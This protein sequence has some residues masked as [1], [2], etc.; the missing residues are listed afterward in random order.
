MRVDRTSG[1]IRGV[2][3]LGAKS[4][5]NRIYLP[6]AIKGGLHLYEGISVRIGHRKSPNELRDPAEMFGW[7]RKCRIGEDG[8]IFADLHFLKSHPMAE[9]V[10]EA[11]ERNPQL[12]CLSHDAT[13][14]GENDSEGRFRVRK[15]TGLKSVDVVVDGGVNVSLFEERE[16]SIAANDMKDS[17]RAACHEHVERALE[18]DEEA[19]GKIADLVGH[20]RGRPGAKEEEE[21]KLARVEEDDE[22]HEVP[23]SPQERERERGMGE[24]RRPRARPATDEAFLEAISVPVGARFLPRSHGHRLD[25]PPS[26][27]SA[28][29]ARG[30]GASGSWSSEAFLEAISTPR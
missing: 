30:S 8:A 16:Q 25:A 9:R 4:H 11:A 28:P 14:E 10:C 18:G 26:R 7:L 24:S 15:L 2:R 29:P 5:N 20:Y 27:V 6:E 3:V 1:V 17:Y 12:F 22:E 13:G 21:E 23:V 19:I